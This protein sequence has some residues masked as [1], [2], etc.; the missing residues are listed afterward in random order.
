MSVASIKLII[1]G[2]AKIGATFFSNMFEKT[3]TFD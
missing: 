2:E 1:R 3:F